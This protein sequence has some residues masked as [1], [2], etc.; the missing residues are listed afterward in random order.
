VQPFLFCQ[1]FKGQKISKAN[2]LET[3]AQ[4]ANENVEGVLP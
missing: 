1:G 3:L 2:F 4:K